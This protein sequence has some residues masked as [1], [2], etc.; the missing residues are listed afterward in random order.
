MMQLGH[1]T[2]KPVFAV[3]ARAWTRRIDCDRDLP[4]TLVETFLRG[5][6]DQLLAGSEPLQVK[7]RC[8]AARIDDPAGPLLVKR[9][10]W[11]DWRRTA[12]MLLRAP[13]SR[14]SAAF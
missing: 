7:D 14:V 1:W 13:T 11:G 9:H 3:R 6:P 10:E 8:A 5:D 2:S 4:A 12:R